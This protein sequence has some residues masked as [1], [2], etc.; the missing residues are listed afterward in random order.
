MSTVEYSVRVHQA[1][2]MVSV[3]AACT[4]DEALTKLHARARS[5][6]QTVEEVAVAVV[7]RRTRFS[8]PLSLDVHES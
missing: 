3:Q 5:T 2:G 1:S 7:E 6:G 8:E 4:I